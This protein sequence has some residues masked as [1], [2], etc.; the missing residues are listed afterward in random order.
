MNCRIYVFGEVSEV[1]LEKIG[2]GA[3]YERYG[4]GE[5][6]LCGRYE[7]VYSERPGLLGMMRCSTVFASCDWQHDV[8]ARRVV[9]LARLL[10]KRV[11]YGED[12][13][14]R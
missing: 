10:G 11:I 8:V 12:F 3:F 14:C 13:R 1:C 6:G 9:R 7:V 5:E 4:S 2:T